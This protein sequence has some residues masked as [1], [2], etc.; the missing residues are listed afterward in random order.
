M[1][2]VDDEVC[3]QLGA[4]GLHEDMDLARRTRTAFG[5]ADD[6]AHGVAGGD[7]AGP[8]ELFT[9]LKGNVGNLTNGGID[10]IERALREGINLHG[11]DEAVPYWLDARS[12][13]GLVNPCGGICGLGRA[14]GGLDPLQLAGQRQRPRQ[15]DY[16]DGRWRFD[17]LHG[18]SRI[19]VGD[20]G[21]WVRG[22]A[23][24][25]RGCR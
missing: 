16:G 20:L 2:G 8:D 10:L 15:L 1:I 24:G 6:P 14:S 3:H 11:V 13:V 9:R 19:V 5:I 4:G 17:R 23:S 18:G 22:G 12:G 21:R 7:G 25:E